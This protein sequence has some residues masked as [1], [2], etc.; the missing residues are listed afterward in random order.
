M[1]LNEHEGFFPPRYQGRAPASGD[2][3]SCWE[4][5]H[6]TVI[7][8]KQKVNDYLV[9]PGELR[10][11][12]WISRSWQGRKWRFGWGGTYG[13]PGYGE[14]SASDWQYGAFKLG[15]YGDQ[16]CEPIKG[17]WTNP[18]PIGAPDHVNHPMA[19]L[20]ETASN[21]VPYPGYSKVSLD[22]VPGRGQ[23][24]YMVNLNALKPSGYRH[25]DEFKIASQV[26]FMTGSYGAGTGGV[27]SLYWP[28][29]E[30]G[31][32]VDS[33]PAESPVDWRHPGPSANV[34][35]LDGH[36][37]RINKTDL[38]ELARKWGTYV[39]AW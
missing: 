3:T 27:N 32:T 37:E 33:P 21:V 38:M 26:P 30:G 17:E 1:Y 18:W 23:M 13:V 24:Q 28:S 20:G 7:M 31:A 19:E 14:G 16:V 6:Q 39:G 35:F 22:P 2:G 11:E 9:S 4:Q 10:S 8:W 15:G 5:E 25:I 36:V 29:H 12:R 34:L